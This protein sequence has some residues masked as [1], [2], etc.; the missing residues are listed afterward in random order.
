MF[1]GE[2]KFQHQTQDGYC[3]ATVEIYRE[4]A[5]GF[6]LERVGTVKVREGTVEL[7]SQSL[8]SVAQFQH[9]LTEAIAFFRHHFPG[10]LPADPILSLS[11]GVGRPPVRLMAA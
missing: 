11:H 5:S 1:D 10:S 8:F 6:E 3:S 2:I 9:I 7:S 4:D